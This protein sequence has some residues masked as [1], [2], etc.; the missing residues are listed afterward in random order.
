MI[1]PSVSAFNGHDTIPLGRSSIATSSNPSTLL[2]TAGV[3]VAAAAVTAAGARRKTP[4]DSGD[5][6]VTRRGNPHLEV[7][8]GGNHL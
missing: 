4:G 1:T 6:L 5:G 7:L 3:A 8:V 2:P